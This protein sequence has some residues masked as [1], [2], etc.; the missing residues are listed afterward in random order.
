MTIGIIGLGLIGGS[1]ALDLRTAGCAA[2]LIGSDQNP[3]HAAKALDLKLIDQ[4]MPIEALVKEAELIILA[5]PV[6]S[7]QSLLLKVLDQIQEHQCI[8]DVGSTKEGI[9]KKAD[10]HPNRPRYV[11]THPMAGTEHS[12]PEAAIAGLFTDKVCIICDQNRSAL[13]AIKKVKQIYAALKMKLIYMD[14]ASH[15][16]HAAYVSHISHISA[17]VLSLA[18]LEKEKSEKTLLD[19]ASGGFDSSVR[20]A[21]SDP[22]MW[23]QI[24]TQNKSHLLEVLDAYGAHLDKFRKYINDSDEKNLYKLIEKANKIRKALK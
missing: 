5:I 4:V 3:K 22:G 8:M 9:C 10:K 16:M 1:M 12:G 15:D 19:M 14:S 24:F 20:L 7:A 21:K 11:A 6:R 17:F 2:K 18:V 23:S 13:T